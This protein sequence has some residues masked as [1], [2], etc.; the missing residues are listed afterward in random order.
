[1]PVGLDAV[2]R[3]A[4]AS[5]PADRYESAVHLAADLERWLADEPVS[6][7]RESAAARARRW[8]RRHARLATGAAAAL[9]VGLVALALLAWQSDRARRALDRQ[10]LRAVAARDRTRAALDAMTS[11]VT[12]DALTVQSALSREQRQFLEGVLKYY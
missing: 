6:C 3:K 5:A 4:L 2:G 11:A 10:R 12:G 1:V 7:L 9:L 8:V